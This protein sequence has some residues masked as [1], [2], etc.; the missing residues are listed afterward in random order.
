MFTPR[1]LSVSCLLV[2]CLL[3]MVL[4]QAEQP[5]NIGQKPSQTTTTVTASATAERVRFTAPSN[6]VRMQL[7]IIS[8]IGQIVFE[9]SSKG[10]VLDWSLQDGSGQRLQGS[11]LTV[12]T[13]K[14]ISGRM[15]EKIGTVSVEEK[16]VRL[17]AGET[18][19][20]TAP[21]QQAVGPVEEKAML[22]I[23]QGDEGQ[24]VT[25]LANDGKQAEALCHSGW[26]TSSA[27]R[28]KSKCA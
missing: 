11:Y 28:M 8:E 3:T 20:L 22:T 2:L 19:E 16:Q 21:Q 23:L 24:P 7:Q 14:S 18:T 17:R 13:V 1:R 5:G 15:S 6:V 4:A 10:N 26:A 25:V 12:V 9:V 27:A